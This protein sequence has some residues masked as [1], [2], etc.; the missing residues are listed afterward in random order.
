MTS[1]ERKNVDIKWNKSVFVLFIHFLFNFTSRMKILQTQIVCVSV[2][3][4][5]IHA[6]KGS[7]RSKQ[8][9]IFYV[10]WHSKQQ[11]YTKHSLVLCA[12]HTYLGKGQR[13]ETRKK[14][15]YNNFVCCSTNKH[16]LNVFSLPLF[17]CLPTGVIVAILTSFFLLLL[18][19]P[20]PSV[21]YCRWHGRSFRLCHSQQHFYLLFYYAFECLLASRTSVFNNDTVDDTNNVNR[22]KK[23]AETAMHSEHRYWKLM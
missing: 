11:Q 17:L 12:C 18:L 10:K 15:K 23:K 14:N 22:T 20:L 19:L 6:T 1:C 4:N 16:L 3:R 2:C 9:W 21:L 8:K 7:R 13:K 5:L